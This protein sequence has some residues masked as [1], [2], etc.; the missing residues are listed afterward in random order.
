MVLTV[1]DRGTHVAEH[2]RNHATTFQVLDGRVIV[3]LLEASFHLTAGELLTIERDVPHAIVA[4]D[5]SAL[6]LTITKHRRSR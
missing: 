5:D 2:R 4:V 3:A 6:V 1:L